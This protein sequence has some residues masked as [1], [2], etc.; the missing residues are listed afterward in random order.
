MKPTILILAIISVLSFAFAQSSRTSYSSPKKR[1]TQA[2]W[3]AEQN[4]KQAQRFQDAHD[5]RCGSQSSDNFYELPAVKKLCIKPPPRNCLKQDSYVPAQEQQRAK[6]LNEQ[7]LY[8][9][10]ITL[11]L[12]NFTRSFPRVSISSLV[13]DLN[14]ISSSH[15]WKRMANSN[16]TPL[17]AGD[18]KRFRDEISGG[19]SSVDSSLSDLEYRATHNGSSQ[20]RSIILGNPECDPVNFPE[21][22]YFESFAR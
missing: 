5:R 2:E 11:R 10:K 15:A 21:R 4:R 20:P 13:S 17:F 7:A 8:H 12:V 1:L 16:I 19:L 6:F 3:Y 22:W 14:R 18:D 9:R